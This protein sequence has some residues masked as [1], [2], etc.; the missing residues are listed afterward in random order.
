[1]VSVKQLFQFVL[2]SILKT[3]CVTQL[4]YNCR[5][6]RALLTCVGVSKGG[7]GAAFLISVISFG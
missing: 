5:L 7:G 1:M 3:S 2:F 4:K 6:V